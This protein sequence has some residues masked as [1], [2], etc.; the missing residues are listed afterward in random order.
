MKK[1]ALVL[2]TIL[3]VGTTASA[4]EV[5]AAP[6]QTVEPVVVAPV[7]AK[8]APLTSSIEFGYEMENHFN[9]ESNPDPK[10]NKTYTRGDIFSPYVVLD[11][12]PIQSAPLKFNVKYMYTEQFGKAKETTYNSKF[13]TNRNRVDFYATGYDWKAGN[14][15]FAPRIGFRWE[16]FE[17]NERSTSTQTND[18]FNLRLYPNMTYK[19]TDNA[20]LYMDGFT[21][22]AFVE[23]DGVGR[24]DGS[25]DQKVVKRRNYD[26]DWYQELQV[27]GLRYRLANKNT[28]WTSLYSEYKDTE[29]VERYSRWQARLGYNWAVTSNLAINPYM[30]YDLDYDIE[31]KAK[32]ATNGLTKDA[33]GVRVGTTA[34]YKL[35]PTLTLLGEVY[36]D[37]AVQTDYDGREYEDRDKIFTKLGF[38]KMF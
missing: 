7:V 2:G 11:F 27:I 29:S 17:I 31:S 18:Y 34:T 30:R 5:V 25:S 1:L 16:T 12:K 38:R 10:L 21:G 37:T 36:Y 26:N 8:P 14:Y 15:T 3:L 23:T 20:T 6:V 28:V 24:L 33:K 13:R 22:P 32:S 4:K 9:H 19:L 35:N